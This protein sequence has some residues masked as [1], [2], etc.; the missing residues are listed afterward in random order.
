MRSDRIVFLVGAL[1]PAA[2]AAWLLWNGDGSG[3]GYVLL[4]LSAAVAWMAFSGERANDAFM[5]AMDTAYVWFRRAVFYVAALWFA[6]A[7]VLMW[8]T[9]PGSVGNLVA[10]LLL[11]G[12][13]ALFVRIGTRGIPKP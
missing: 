9:Q 13:A 2:F 1:I 10:E 5:K 4:M 6:A 3:T 7:A 12:L 8:L 11:L